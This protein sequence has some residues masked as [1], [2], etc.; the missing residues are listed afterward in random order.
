[1][2][3]ASGSTATEGATPDAYTFCLL[4]MRR[5]D[6]IRGATPTLWMEDAAANDNADEKVAAR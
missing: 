6:N 4:D 1:M 2:A 3:R 5:S